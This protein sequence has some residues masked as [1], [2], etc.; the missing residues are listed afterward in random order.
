MTPIFPAFRRPTENS[1]PSVDKEPPGKHGG[2]LCVCGL[3]S[4]L[5]GSSELRQRQR[6]R[7]VSCASVS[8]RV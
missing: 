6:S 7:R 5:F 3:Q 2:S 4:R 8:H 1:L